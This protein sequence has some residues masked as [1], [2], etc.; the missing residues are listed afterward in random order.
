MKVKAIVLFSVC[1]AACVQSYA[2]VRTEISVGERNNSSLSTADFDYTAHDY[3]IGVGIGSSKMYGDLPYSNPQP[4]YT[5]DV[6]KNIG[7][8][9]SMGWQVQIGDLS[10]RDPYTHMRSFNH[11]TSFDGHITCEIGTLFSLFDRSYEEAPVL[12]ALSGLY[13]GIGIGVVNSDVKRIADFD[14][15]ALPGITHTSNPPILTNSAAIFIP[16]NFGYNLHLPRIW[17]FDAC[18]FYFNFQYADVMSDYVDGYKLPLKA[19]KNND[20]FTVMSV[21]FR[22]FVFHSN[23]VTV[24]EE[25]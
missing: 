5:I 23:R 3:C 13:A 11:F 2:Q 12:Y 21:G 10:S 22:A 1:L 15:Q 18:M 4:V 20:V 17:K 8:R 7:P 16:F 14:V 25:Y 24:V 9:F 6:N 19:N